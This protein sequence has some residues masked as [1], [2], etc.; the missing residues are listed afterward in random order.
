MYSRFGLLID[1]AWR[2]ASET[3][4]PENPAGEDAACDD[5]PAARLA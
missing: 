4:I 1:G 5:V 3:L 2:P